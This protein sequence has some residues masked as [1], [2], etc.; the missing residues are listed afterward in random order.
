VD[1]KRYSKGKMVGDEQRRT[2]EAAKGF[3]DRIC[4]LGGVACDF[5]G[6]A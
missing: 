4:I 1:E 3:S 2:I 5:V 6:S